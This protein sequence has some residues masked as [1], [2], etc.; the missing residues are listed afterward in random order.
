MSFEKLSLTAV[1]PLEPS[2]GRG[3]TGSPAN[4]PPASSGLATAAGVLLPVSLI[5]ISSSAPVP[6]DE[7]ETLPDEA[8]LV[9]AKGRGKVSVGHAAHLV[10]SRLTH[11]SACG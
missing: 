10:P 6:W 9:R 1:H 8:C 7:G 3:G 4:D 11:G 2:G 5:S